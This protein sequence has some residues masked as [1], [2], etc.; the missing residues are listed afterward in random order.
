[1]LN[2]KREK[3]R[4]VG[5]WVELHFRTKNSN[6]HQK[7]DMKTFNIKW[8]ESVENKSETS[9]RLRIIVEMC[10]CIAIDFSGRFCWYDDGLPNAS[11]HRLVNVQNGFSKA[12]AIAKTLTSY[13][14]QVIALYAINRSDEYKWRE[15]TT[16][17]INEIKFSG[18]RYR[19]SDLARLRKWREKNSH[20]N[21]FLKYSVYASVF[22]GIL[23]CC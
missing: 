10:W 9:N 11:C 14:E 3:H 17:Y 12:N 8:N 4:F 21:D 7:P 19:I 22:H 5:I 1:M 16:K 13:G 18:A 23:E 6:T 20:A 15:K 2:I